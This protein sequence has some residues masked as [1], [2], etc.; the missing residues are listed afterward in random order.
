MVKN[1]LIIFVLFLCSCSETTDNIYVKVDP[2]IEQLF[3]QKA[4]D[5]ASDIN[6]LKELGKVIQVSPNWCVLIY[7]APTEG[8]GYGRAVVYKKSHNIWE[9]HKSTSRVLLPN[10][11][12]KG[13]KII[14]TAKVSL[15][16]STRI[17]IMCIETTK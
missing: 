12:L 9:V 17:Q 1:I 13:K 14:V 2:K 6:T 15:S 10:A 4:P 8:V 7:F 11:E 5:S 16:D 3:T